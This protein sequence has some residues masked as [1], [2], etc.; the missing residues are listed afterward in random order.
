[1]LYF[2]AP[3]CPS[4]LYS[5]CLQ[6]MFCSS[7]PPA[8]QCDAEAAKHKPHRQG[9]LYASEANRKLQAQKLSEALRFSYIG[10]KHPLLY[11]Y[12]NSWDS[13]WCDLKWFHE[14]SL[15]LLHLVPLRR[16]NCF[17]DCSFANLKTFLI[18]LTMKVPTFESMSNL[19]KKV[20]DHV[21]LNFP[22]MLQ[23]KDLS[24]F[25]FFAQH[26]HSLF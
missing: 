15:H 14:L 12:L 23:L 24:S 13:S 9:F 11:V 3:S 19:T 26:H 8:G 1:M 10:K 5:G 21:Y 18:Y 7:V 4:G 20:S 22:E 25:S 17:W 2:C 6:G 16:K